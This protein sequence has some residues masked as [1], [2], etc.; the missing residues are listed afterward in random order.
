[1]LMRFNEM[2]VNVRFGN[3]RIGR[4]SYAGYSTASQHTAEVLQCDDKYAI[5]HSPVDMSDCFVPDK[6]SGVLEAVPQARLGIFLDT[7]EQVGLRNST[8]AQNLFTLL[9]CPIF[10]LLLWPKYAVMA[11]P[12][13]SQL[14]RQNTVTY[15]LI[16]GLLTITVSF[17]TGAIVEVPGMEVHMCHVLRMLLHGLV[18][19][20][21]PTA[22][23]M[24]VQSEDFSTR[25]HDDGATTAA[26]FRQVV[27][28]IPTQYSRQKSEQCTPR[29]RME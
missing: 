17:Q 11:G 21:L 26:F 28:Q 4:P 22:K 18:S 13:H 23:V 24:S 16:I 2:H 9:N 5:P 3:I 6:V 14:Q 12:I 20:V 27:I 15:P 8:R 19:V 1:M 10:E 7:E 29:R 25:R